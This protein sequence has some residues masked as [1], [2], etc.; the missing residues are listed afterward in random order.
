M[1]EPLTAVIRTGDAPGGLRGDW[2]VLQMLTP[3][4]VLLAETQPD[5]N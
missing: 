3:Y 5:A 1:G 2:P 4:I